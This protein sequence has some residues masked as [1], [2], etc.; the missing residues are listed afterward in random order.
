MINET[1]KTYH[2]NYCFFKAICSILFQIYFQRRQANNAAGKI[3]I[4][5]FWCEALG[6]FQ[7]IVDAA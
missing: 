1:A 2:I 5:M 7:Y 6:D 4:V 3:K